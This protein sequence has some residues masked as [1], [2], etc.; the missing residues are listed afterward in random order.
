MKFGLT[1]EDLKSIRA[2]L[3]KFP[4][5]KKMEIFGSRAMGTEK[6][7]SD[8]DLVIYGQIPHDTLT[9]IKFILEEEIPL[10]YHFDIIL[11]DEIENQA[12]KKHIREHGQEFYKN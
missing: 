5:I 11:W 3:E 10:P 7:G 2:V 8:I 6:T 1:S 12:L 9:Q 4:L